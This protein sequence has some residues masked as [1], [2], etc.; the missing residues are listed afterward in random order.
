MPGQKYEDG[1]LT[2]IPDGPE[3]LQT[4]IELD[5]SCL[6]YHAYSVQELPENELYIR[7]PVNLSAQALLDIA[8]YVAANKARLEQEA[9]EDYVRNERAM[10]AEARDMRQI[11]EEWHT[12]RHTD[13][14]GLGDE[15]GPLVPQ[16]E[17]F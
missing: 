13:T 17:D 7:E 8:V 2:D 6:P 3:E 4:S 9:Q 1:T 14:R 16:K 5:T 11:A 12:Y 15:T 10:I